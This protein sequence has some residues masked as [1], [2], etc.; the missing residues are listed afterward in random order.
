MSERDGHAIIT[1]LRMGQEPYYS[2]NFVVAQRQS[3]TFTPMTPT[4]LRERPPVGL[5]LT[6]LWRRALGEQVPPPR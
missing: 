2:F 5:G 6:W 3:P 1:D 4:S